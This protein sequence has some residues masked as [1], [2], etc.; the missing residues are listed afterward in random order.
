[1]NFG[2]GFDDDADDRL[3]IASCQTPSIAGSVRHHRKSLPPPGPNDLKCLICMKTFRI[4]GNLE[5]HHAWH[6]E[7]MLEQRD[8]TISTPEPAEQT[9]LVQQNMDGGLDVTAEL[10]LQEGMRFYGS[11][12]INIMP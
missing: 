2:D 11:V 3:S 4:K 7:H 6:L 8:K 5:K 1:M 10:G 9:L 12:M